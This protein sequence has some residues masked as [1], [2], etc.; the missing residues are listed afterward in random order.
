MNWRGWLSWAGVDRP[1]AREPL[2]INAYPLVIEAARA[3]QGIALG[4]HR[5]VDADLAAGALVRPLPHSART[6]FGY[7]LVWSA[8]RALPPVAEGFRDWALGQV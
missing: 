4:W 7:Y 8:S 1:A 3:G 6:R 2:R 5:L